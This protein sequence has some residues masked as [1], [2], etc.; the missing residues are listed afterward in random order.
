MGE[1]TMNRSL[2]LSL[3]VIKRRETVLHTWKLELDVIRRF[4]YL[5]K[6]KEIELEIMAI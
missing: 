1:L 3:H 2:F 6:K 4:S 5:R